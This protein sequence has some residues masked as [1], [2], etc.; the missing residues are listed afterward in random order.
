MITITAEQLAA[1]AAWAETGEDM[2]DVTLRADDRMLLVSQGDEYAAFDTGGEPGSEEYLQAAPL[3]AETPATP[4]APV[5]TVA[6]V[7]NR[8]ARI[9]MDTGV[10]CENAEAGPGLVTEIIPGWGPAG[11]V[12]IR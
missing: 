3:D 1:A 10:W 9:P 4:D 7:M 5:A 8:L 12:M 6:G 2:A 11:Q